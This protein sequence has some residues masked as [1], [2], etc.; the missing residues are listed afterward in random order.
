MEAKRLILKGLQASPRDSMLW[1]HFAKIEI[2]LQNFPR[3][4]ALFNRACEVNP[5]DW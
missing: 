4:R 5:N 1:D 3:A 2:A